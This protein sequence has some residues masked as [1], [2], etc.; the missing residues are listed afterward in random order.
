MN[1]KN[2]FP[3]CPLNEEFRGQ[4]ERRIYGIREAYSAAIYGSGASA[5][6]SI[7]YYIIDRGA[8]TRHKNEREGVD[9][10]DAGEENGRLP[11]HYGFRRQRGRTA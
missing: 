9:A 7:I 5:I 2:F 3:F 10:D 4:T 6:L 11:R 8:F 1:F